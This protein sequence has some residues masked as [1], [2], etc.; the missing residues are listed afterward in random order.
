MKRTIKNILLLIMACATVLSGC[1]VNENNV[2]SSTVDST[3]LIPAEAYDGKNYL[4]ESDLTAIGQELEKAEDDEDVADV[5][6]QCEVVQNFDNELS[7][8]TYITQYDGIWFI[9]DCYHNRVIFSEELEVPLNEWYIMS[10]DATQPHT[11]ASDG[12]VY[13]IDDTENNRV[14]IYEKINGLFVH[15]QTFYDIGNRPHYTL[16]NEITD[17]FYVW[18]STT[19]ELYCFRHTA[20]STRMYLT[21]IRKID[22]LENIYVR[23]FS[24][25]DGYIYFVS[26]VSDTASSAASNILKCDLDTLEIKEKY[27]VPPEVSGMVQITKIQ[28][29]YYISVSTDTTG[30]QDYATIVKTPSLEDLCQGKYEDIYSK[31]FIGGGTPYYI[32]N[33]GDTY[34]LTE[35]RLKGHSIWSFKVT[36][37]KIVDVKSVF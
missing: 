2:V 20:D 32:S 11:I 5:L 27:T 10:S 9:V 34:F 30:S 14:L 33:V 37:N 35:H 4:S 22:E 31:Y 24:I 13:M 21:D 25:I 8:P 6:A 28:D 23:S 16:Y 36:D 3:T 1:K 7:V 15:T 18:S 12:T 26:G 19:G 17:T 29:Y